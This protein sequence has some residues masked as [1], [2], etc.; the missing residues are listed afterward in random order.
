[1]SIIHLHPQFID[2]L[3]EDSM[4]NWHIIIHLHDVPIWTAAQ[5]IWHRISIGRKSQLGRYEL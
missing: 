2:R 3:S 5:R 1:M 4:R